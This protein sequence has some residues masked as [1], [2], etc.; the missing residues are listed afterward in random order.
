MKEI[1]R[2]IEEHEDSCGGIEQKNFDNLAKAI[3]QYVEQQVKM[4]VDDAKECA[5]AYSNMMMEKDKAH[6]QYVIK[7][8]LDTMSRL[9]GMS[10]KQ[11]NEWIA[12]LKKG[13]E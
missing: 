4:Y 1:E 8:R 7:A 5:T 12:E 9:M 2:I 6:E 10:I 11:K 13:L 3:E